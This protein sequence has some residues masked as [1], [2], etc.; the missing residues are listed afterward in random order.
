MAQKYQFK[1][2]INEVD[3]IFQRNQTG[4]PDS[5]WASIILSI[6]GVPLNTFTPQLSGSVNSGNKFGP[7]WE[8]FAVAGAD[9][10]VQL[11]VV[12]TNLSKTDRYAQGEKAIEIT[13]AV[14]NSIV[15]LASPG[16]AIGIEL[17]WAVWGLLY[18]QRDPDCDG[19]IFSYSQGWTASDLLAMC[20]NVDR[21]AVLSQIK[22]DSSQLHTPSECGHDPETSITFTASYEETGQ[23]DTPA[24][25][26]A[27]VVGG[28]LSGWIGP[29][30][31][32]P[33]SSQSKLFAV[34]TL[35][36][37]AA[38]P[39]SHIEKARQSL[40]AA[41]SPNADS[42]GGQSFPLVATRVV[43]SMISLDVRTDETSGEG[44]GR[45]SRPLLRENPRAVPVPVQLPPYRGNIWS[46]AGS[47]A[48]AVEMLK[49]QI[50]SVETLVPRGAKAI[51]KRGP[52]TNF[53]LITN[54]EH[55]A[56]TVFLPNDISLSMYALVADG[57]TVANR[58]RYL[59]R[60]DQGRT[61]VDVLLE[62]TA[63]VP[64]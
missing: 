21:S 54:R 37:I 42:G 61:I 1:F 35:N 46:D 63:T 34:V 8:V 45:A 20:D 29:W 56:D 51:S 62:H 59:R 12:M 40:V 49:S 39:I 18:G 11:T 16:L 57:K 44:H 48:R 23:F 47:E 17:V 27:E 19:I 15:A 38:L 43:N 41:T 58:L 53:R 52:E 50:E 4:Y 36:N 60:D 55:I 10:L 32:A 25:T 33:F 3:V 64:R 26:L 9:Q 13:G 7:N 2:V 28:G 30:S 22:G 24:N 6:D 5:D 31:D 14:C